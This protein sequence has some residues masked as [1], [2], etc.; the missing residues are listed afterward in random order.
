MMKTYLMETYLMD[1]SIEELEA[2]LD[3]LL[4]LRHICHEETWT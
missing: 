4:D 3:S 1:A 2:E